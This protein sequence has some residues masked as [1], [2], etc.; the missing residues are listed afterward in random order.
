MASPLPARWGTPSS[1]HDPHLLAEFQPRSDDVLITTAPKS[2]TTW[3]QQIL[4]QLRT[5]GDEHF[6][7]IFEVVPWLELPQ[8]HVSRAERLTSFEA[9]STPRVFKTHCLA[10]QTPGIDTVRLIMT[11]RDPRD[12]CI[13]MYHHRMDFTQTVADEKGIPYPE[14]FEAFFEEWMKTGSWFRSATSWWPERHRENLLWLR[15]ADLRQDLRGGV[16]QINRFLGWNR[17]DEVCDE[18]VRLSGL[19]WMKANQIKF[20]RFRSEDAS[21]FKP[22]GFIRKGAIGEGKAKLTETQQR[23]I[24]DRV[25]AEIPPE[26]VSFLG[27]E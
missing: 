1:V 12:V 23:R 5:G 16:D 25:H 22:G 13:S 24:M 2:G 26:C 19:A 6:G 20:T 18:V 15:Y 8:E 4:H 3:M 11:S 14:S 9:M 27:L 21:H 10:E 7:S 17:S